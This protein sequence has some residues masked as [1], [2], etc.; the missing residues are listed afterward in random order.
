MDYAIQSDVTVVKNESGGATNRAYVGDTGGNMWRVDFRYDAVN[1]WSNTLVTQL[2]SVGGSGAVKRKFQY[3]PDVVGGRPFGFNYDAVL[4]G[5]GDREHPFDTSVTNRFYMFKDT[6][7]DAGPITGRQAPPEHSRIS[8]KPRPRC[9][10]QP[11][12]AYR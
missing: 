6:G 12:T 10:M 4:I 5:S 11:T 8:R 1:G 3:P 2:A 7:D 9:S